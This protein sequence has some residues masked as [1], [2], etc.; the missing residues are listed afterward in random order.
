MNR[1][2]WFNV[3][4]TIIIILEIGGDLVYTIIDHM[5]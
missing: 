1:M 2:D 4:A 5:K 3:I